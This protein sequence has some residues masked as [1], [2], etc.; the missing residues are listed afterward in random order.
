METT[1]KLKAVVSVIYRLYEVRGAPWRVTPDMIRAVE[2]EHF[3]AREFW[4]CWR[5]YDAGIRVELDEFGRLAAK[6]AKKLMQ[7]G[8]PLRLAL[9][10][11]WAARKAS[12]PLRPDALTEAEAAVQR[13]LE[14]ID[15][16]SECLADCGDAL[17][18]FA[19]E[20]FWYVHCTTWLAPTA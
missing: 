13:V 18:R 2:R 3:S 9:Q 7:Q 14:G 15:P 12:T 19:A 16:R 17:R 4:A 8:A 20:V 5:D 1:T 10:C 11:I 6:T